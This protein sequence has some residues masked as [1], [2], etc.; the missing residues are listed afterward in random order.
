ML[1][2][3]EEKLIGII[4]GYSKRS[5]SAFNVDLVQLAPGNKLLPKMTRFIIIIIRLLSSL[6]AFVFVYIKATFK[7]ARS[8]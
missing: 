3:R 4:Y 8:I 2:F 1:L 6:P 5:M 7:F